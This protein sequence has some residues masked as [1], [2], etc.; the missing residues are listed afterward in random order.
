MWGVLVA[1]T[2]GCFFLLRNDWHGFFKTTTTGLHFQV[3]SHGQGPTPREGEMLLLHMCYKTRSGTTLFNTADQGF[4]MAVPY[5]KALLKKDGGFLEAISMLTKTGDHYRFR[6]NAQQLFGEHVGHLC[7]HYGLHRDAPIFLHLQLKESMIE[8]TYKQW[9]VEKTAIHKEK[10]Q[11]KMENQLKKDIQ[12]ITSYLA[13]H[14][15]IAHVTPNNLYYT[16]DSPG[17]GK[18]PQLGNRVKIHYTGKLLNGKVFDTSREEISKQHHIHNPRKTYAAIE[19]Q[20][21][22]GQV[23][24]GW[25][26]GILHLHQGDKGRFFIPSNLAYGSRSLKGLIPPNAILIFD[27]EV[28]DVWD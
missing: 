12:E 4:P 24:Q 2:V 25:E 6:L 10:Q 26:E 13:M 1:I 20:L 3:I 22:V 17:R 8:Q 18:K 21:G 19:F 5:E 15:I 14:K 7:S 28:V 23:I 16:I 9:E 11:K 27:V